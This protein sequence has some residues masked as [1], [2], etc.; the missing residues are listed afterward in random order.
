MKFFSLFVILVIYLSVRVEAKIRLH[1]SIKKCEGVNEIKLVVIL[2]D[3]ATEVWAKSEVSRYDQQ[4]I[5]GPEL[6]D[7]RRRE[8]FLRAQEVLNSLVDQPLVVAWDYY[9]PKSLVSH[10]NEESPASKDLAK[11]FSASKVPLV[12]ASWTGGGELDSRIHLNGAH[13][14]QGHISLFRDEIGNRFS[15]VS[16]MDQR[17]RDYLTQDT[18]AIATLAA[19]LNAKCKA[20][21]KSSFQAARQFFCSVA[22]QKPVSENVRVRENG[23]TFQIKGIKLTEQPLASFSMKDLINRE[24]AVLDALKGSVVLFGNAIV[25]VDQIFK[26]EKQEAKSLVFVHAWTIAD[27]LQRFANLDMPAPKKKSGLICSN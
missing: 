4:M 3:V 26:K 7:K 19:T 10:S 15:P 24:P 8:L 9:F 17:L 13:R 1:T 5:V 16:K 11:A 25:D 22:D 27:I 12:L 23:E 14:Y 21:R 2:E 6:P 18:F 20:P